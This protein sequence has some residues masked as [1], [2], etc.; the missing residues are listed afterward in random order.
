M[1]RPLLATRK[2]STFDIL[3]NQKYSKYYH[4]LGQSYPL[5]NKETTFYGIQLELQ[6]I[7]SFCVIASIDILSF[8]PL[9]FTYSYYVQ[10]NMRRFKIVRFEN[11]K[12]NI[13][14]TNC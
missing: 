4:N 2:T 10:R 11:N 8:N 5:K 12:F 3:Q 13:Y 14:F 9:R 6:C 7:R 1:L